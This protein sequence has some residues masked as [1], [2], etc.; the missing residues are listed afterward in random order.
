MRETNK[1]R[2]TFHTEGGAIFAVDLIL[3][4]ESGVTLKRNLWESYAAEYCPKE[5]THLR[6][7]VERGIA[8]ELRNKFIILTKRLRKEYVFPIPVSV[9]IVNSEK[10]TLRS[11]KQTYGS[12]R[13]FPNRTPRIIIP[14]AYE[15]SELEKHGREE[16]D[17][18]ILSSLIHEL[19][20]YF[21]YCSDLEQS[22]AISERQA[23]YYRYLI[24]EKLMH[25]L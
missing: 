19:T 7:H 25:E 18:M 3:R 9:Y 15:K 2:S 6:L 22:N 1:N 10:I 20:H 11:G 21:Q 5:T 13:W 17:V 4:K 23:N 14:A 24:V 16:L 8:P 12:F